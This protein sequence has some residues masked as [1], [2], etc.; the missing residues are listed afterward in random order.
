VEDSGNNPAPDGA[1]KEPTGNKGFVGWI[2]QWGFAILVA[3]AVL[4][5]AYLAW[6]VHVPTRVPDFALK[7]PAIYRIEIG[8]GAFLGLYLVTMAFV[9]ALNNRGFSEI[10]V[11][12][13]KA[14]DMANKAQQD[15]IQSHEDSLEILSG[16]V[17]DIE[18]STGKSV[19]NLQARLEALEDAKGK[20]SSQAKT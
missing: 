11:N 3:L 12:G 17:D 1:E 13:L 7:A 5:S 18:A 19:Q 4:A 16:M 8:A 10:G 15:A 20:S 2:A 6:K 14:Q 9:L